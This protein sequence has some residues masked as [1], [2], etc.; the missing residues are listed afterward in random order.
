M[1]GAVMFGHREMQ[2]VI[3]A[4]IG[5]AEKA[6]KDPRD[7]PLN[8]TAALLDK[9]KTV[10]GGDLTAAFQIPEKHVRRDRIAEIRKK[11]AESNLSA[12]ARENFPPANSAICFTT[13]KPM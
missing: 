5:L 10:A 8:E 9:L 4:I 7:V 2:A 12:K 13:S 11:T 6:A 3:N 1:L